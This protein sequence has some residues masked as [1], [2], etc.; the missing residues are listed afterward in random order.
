MYWEKLLIHRK[1]NGAYNRH[2]R[3]KQETRGIFVSVRRGSCYTTY[4]RN[5]R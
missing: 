1:H 5:I 4:S 3:S 2:Q